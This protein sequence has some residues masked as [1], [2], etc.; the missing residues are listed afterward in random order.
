MGDLSL[1]QGE[2]SS[3][4][5]EDFLQSNTGDFELK[6]LKQ[7]Q[8]SPCHFKEKIIEESKEFTG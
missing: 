7:T 5:V 4:E 1:K 3:K 8:Q 2:F 6:D